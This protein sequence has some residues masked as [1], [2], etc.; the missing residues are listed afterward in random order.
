MNRIDKHL[1]ELA[2]CL[3]REAKEDSVVFITQIL[4]EVEL[5]NIQAVALSQCCRLDVAAD[6]IQERV[7]VRVHHEER[8]ILRHILRVQVFVD[9]LIHILTEDRRKHLDS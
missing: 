9:T 1:C 3:I 7:L 8:D 4:V 5:G 6:L 2:R